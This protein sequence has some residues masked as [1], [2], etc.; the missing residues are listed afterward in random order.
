MGATGK[1]GAAKATVGRPAKVTVHRQ[2]V[3]GVQGS[4]GKMQKVKVGRPAKRG[5]K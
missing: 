1:G 5:S 4:G 3:T 2:T